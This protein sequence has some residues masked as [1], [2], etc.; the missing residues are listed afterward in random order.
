MYNPY[1]PPYPN[2]LYHHGIKGQEWGV[3]N[4]PPY[5]LNRK[6]G[7]IIKRNTKNFERS[8]RIARGLQGR[9]N[10][11][12]N[13]IYFNNLSE[14]QKRRVETKAKRYE[15]SATKWLTKAQA[16]K[17]TIRKYFGNTKSN[18]EYLRRNYAKSSGKKYDKVFG[19]TI[20]SDISYARD[21][22]LA[23]RIYRLRNE[24]RL[25]R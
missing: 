5:P 3:R 2:E 25:R 12:R 23:D 13:K 24:R 22:T 21:M 9:A 1:R 20:D 4:G 11:I 6:E 17:S 16:D 18:S 8:A 14:S 15:D 19:K 10:R 7:R